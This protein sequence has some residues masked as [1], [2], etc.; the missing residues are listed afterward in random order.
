MSQEIGHINNPSELNHD[1]ASFDEY[2]PVKLK[3]YF[4]KNPIIFFIILV[5]IL[6]CLSY[7]K[8]FPTP[9][10]KFNFPK[11]TTLENAILTIAKVEKVTINI[12]CDENIKKIFVTDDVEISSSNIEGLLD[13]ISTHTNS[14]NL[15]YKVQ[16]INEKSYTIHCLQN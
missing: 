13:N 3:P 7:T 16:K 11:A 14:I 12:V 8:I 6:L 4:V 15:K 5:S 2:N 9:K 1:I 10:I